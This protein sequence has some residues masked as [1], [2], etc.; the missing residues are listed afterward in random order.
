M[1]GRTDICF[2]SFFIKK[3]SNDVKED[4]EFSVYMDFD[5]VCVIVPKATKIPKG[6][7][8]YHFFPLS[9]WICSILS[10][11][12]VYLTWYFLQLFTPGRYD[13]RQNI[14]DVNYLCNVSD[15][16]HSCFQN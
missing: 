13:I 16:T 4:I 8:T 15:K 11:V 12:F 5:R 10:Q 9:V 14:S 2:E 1:H 7:R 3:Y 6:L